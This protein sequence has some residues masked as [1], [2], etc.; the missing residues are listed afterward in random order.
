MLYSTM[1]RKNHHDSTT[2]IGED[3]RALAL[4]AAITAV[5]LLTLVY[6]ER[7]FHPIEQ[8]IVLPVP[9]EPSPA[10]VL[11]APLATS[12]PLPTTTTEQTE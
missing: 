9:A 5:A 7:T 3:L 6:V 1:A 4:T 2:F 12:A 11:D 8:M 10:A